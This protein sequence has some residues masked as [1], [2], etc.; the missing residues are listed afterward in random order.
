MPP[1]SLSRKM[2]IVRTSYARTRS[3]RD[4]EY[5]SLFHMAGIEQIQSRYGPDKQHSQ[6][7]RMVDS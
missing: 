4:S 1:L 3:R 2:K 7:F 5:A 6:T